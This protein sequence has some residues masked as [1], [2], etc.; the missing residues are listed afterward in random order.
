MFRTSG[1]GK[2][3]GFTD[4]AL[5]SPRRRVASFTGAFNFT[6]LPGHFR[7]ILNLFLYL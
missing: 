5:S 4:E 3:A 7:K 1:E 6:N 2:F